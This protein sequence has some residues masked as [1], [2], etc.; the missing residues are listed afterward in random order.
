MG[1]DISLIIT[2][3]TN[4]K[5]LNKIPHIIEN[6]LLIVAL[7][8][9]E[10]SKFINRVLRVHSTDLD[11]YHEDF[12]FIDLIKKLN[13]KTFLGYH[14]SDWGGIPIDSIRFAVI[15]NEIIVESIKSDELEESEDPNLLIPTEKLDAEKILDIQTSKMSYYH[16]YNDF[17]E[18][19]Q[20]SN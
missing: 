10:F 7:K 5:N 1:Q 8:N 14:E 13:I 17:V 2:K 15:D 6:G 19:T 11:Y 18:K 16:T 4:L 20:N 9:N 3:E 12:E